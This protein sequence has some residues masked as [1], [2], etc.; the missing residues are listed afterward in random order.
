[1]AAAAA[2]P[3]ALAAQGREN[4][5]KILARSLFLQKLNKNSNDN[6]YIKKQTEHI[7]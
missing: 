7:H 6:K 3:A 5:M 1:M 2:A 4:E